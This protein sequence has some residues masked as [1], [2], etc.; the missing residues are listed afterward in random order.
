MKYVKNKLNKSDT[1]Q[2]QLLCRVCVVHP[3]CVS[4]DV[5]CSIILLFA[6][7]VMGYP[8]VQGPLRECRSI[9]S[10]FY[11]LPS[12]FAPLVCVPDVIGVLAVWRHNK[13]KT[14]NQIK[15][16]AH[17]QA[18]QTHRTQLSSVQ[19]GLRHPKRGEKYGSSRVNKL[20]TCFNGKNKRT[21]QRE[22]G[23]AGFL[24]ATYCVSYQ[25]YCC[26]CACICTSH[27]SVIQ[28]TVCM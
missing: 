10:G 3:H 16:G 26:R 11:G 12:Y 6:Y 17:N 27:V 8:Q 21:N 15:L 25:S 7:V 19:L 5:F 18:T 2:N 20:N 1:I 4:T 23:D 9:R 13:P 24:C 14:K 22:K 28:C